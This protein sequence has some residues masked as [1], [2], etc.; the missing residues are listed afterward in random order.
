VFSFELQDGLYEVGIDPADRDY[1]IVNVRGEIH[2]LAFLPMGW[3]LSPFFFCNIRQFPLSAGPITTPS[4]IRYYTK[5]FLRRTRWRGA[6]TLHYVDDFI[7]FVSIGEEA[8]AVRRRLANLLD[9][10]G[11]LRHPTK[12]FWQPTQIGHHL[13][14]SLDMLGTVGG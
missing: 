2:L 8:L 12:G 1:F 11:L 7:L 9:R 13:R 4:I 3:P 6:R 5:T 10:I 14:I